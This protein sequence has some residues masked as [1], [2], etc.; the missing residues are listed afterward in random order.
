M[1]RTILMLALA[2]FFCLKADRPYPG[3][4]EETK[5]KI[6]LIGAST[7]ANK[8]EAARP[9]TGWG[10]KF[11][12]FFKD[13]VTV[14]NRALN[15]RST[16]SFRNEGHWDKVM[17]EL[18]AGDWVLIQ[19][20]HNDQKLDKPAVGTTIAEYKENLSRYIDE[21]RSKGATPVVLT[22]IVRRA[23]KNGE[24]TNTHGDY[25]DAVIEVANTMKC[26]YIDMEKK[27]HALVAAYGVEKSKELYFWAKK[28]DFPHLAN[29]KKDNTHF[30][31]YGAQKMAELV[32]EGI[33]EL[34]NKVLAQN[35]KAYK[36]LN[37][38]I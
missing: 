29:D 24:L 30:S 26:E 33:V 23:F 12:P 18:K 13:N 37:Q 16:K 8:K 5:F 19:F 34:K 17:K 22:S 28:Q 20:G 36:K 21:V 11:Q 9:E 3:H 2:A 38:K 10:E 27:S 32:A 7:C 25:P 35:L 15:G 31:N 6:Y 4:R 14:D 1:K